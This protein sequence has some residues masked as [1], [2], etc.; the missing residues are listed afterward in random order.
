MLLSNGLIIAILGAL[1][2]LL[3]ALAAYL[4]I[5]LMRGP[6]EAEIAITAELI[7]E[8][9]RA[10]GKLVGL[11]VCAK[12]IATAKKGWSWLPPLLLSPARLAMIFQFEKQYY[13]DLARVSPR[14]VSDFGNRRYQL[15]LPPVEGVLRLTDVTPYDIQDGRILGLVDVIQMKAE[16]QGELMRRAQDQAAILFE[17]ADPRYLQEARRSIQKQLT[18]LLALFDAEVDVVW[19]DA[20]VTPAAIVEQAPPQQALLPAAAR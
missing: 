7:A 1:A 5:K 12:E 6:R 18:A 15:I 8:R 3:V 19:K 17:T 13:V 14:D 11:E 16:A 2:A 10:A 9:V 4:A 20:L